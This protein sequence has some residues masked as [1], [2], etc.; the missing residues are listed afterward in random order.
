MDRFVCRE[1][2]YTAAAA[3]PSGG[4]ALCPECG[5]S[6][7]LHAPGTADAHSGSRSEGIAAGRLNLRFTAAAG[8]YFRIWIVNTFLTIITLGIYAAWAKVRNRRYF[9]KSTLLDGHSFDYT[10]DPKAILKGH[11]LIAAGVGLYHA[12]NAY[13]HLVSLVLAGLFAL[14]VPLLVYKSLRFFTHNSAYRNIRFRFS[15]TLGESY[16]TYMLI[17]L[18]IP[19]TAGLIFPYWAFRRKSYFFGNLAYGAASASF[20]GRP[21]PFYKMYIAFALAVFALLVM[22]GF[23]MVSIMPLVSDL[24]SFDRQGM[25]NTAALIPVIII[26]STI[27]LGVSFQ[28]VIY[29][30]ATNYCLEH[31]QLGPLRFEGALKASRLLWITLTNILAIMLSLGLLIPWAKV[32]RLRY[33]LEKVTVIPGPG[34]GLDDFTAA[35]EAGETA[36]G[37]AATDFFDIEIGL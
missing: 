6:S 35:A 5:S 22:G 33:I 13:N 1:C 30:W 25:Q 8:E 7:L 11:L 18:L 24:L 10:A 9:Y 29:A 3:G 34:P 4:I 23:V 37:E 19:F 28:Q 2:G 32:R 26:L 16:M 36:Y 12:S 31:T 14:V 27:V 15:G 20:R 21:G 17:P